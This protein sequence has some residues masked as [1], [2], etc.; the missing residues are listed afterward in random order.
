MK[1]GEDDIMSMHFCFVCVVTF[2]GFNS[3]LE[4]SDFHRARTSITDI[5]STQI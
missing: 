4:P 5:D 2:H 3:F 1:Q